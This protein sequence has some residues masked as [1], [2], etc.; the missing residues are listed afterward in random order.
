MRVPV[1]V[2]GFIS[3]AGA[4]IACRLCPQVREYLFAAHRSEERGHALMLKELGLRPLL[5]LGMRLGE[6]TGA[7]LAMLLVEA[8]AKIYAEMATFGQAGV[9]EGR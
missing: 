4:L 9:S 5:E 6:G 2:D 8:G 1:V 7:A 3:T